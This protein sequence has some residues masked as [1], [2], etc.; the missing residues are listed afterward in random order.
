MPEFG[1]LRFVFLILYS[2]N[3]TLDSVSLIKW[4]WFLAA[5]LALLVA[6]ASCGQR[7]NNTSLWGVRPKRLSARYISAPPTVLSEVELNYTV[8]NVAQIPPAPIKSTKPPLWSITWLVSQ[9]VSPVG[10]LC[11]TILLVSEMSLLVRICEL[12]SYGELFFVL[13]ER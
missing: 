9:I 13:H 10:S 7:A 6:L 1:D 2:Q 5:S 8:I 4:T 12:R 11:A 3:F